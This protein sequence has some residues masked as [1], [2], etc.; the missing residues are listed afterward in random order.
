MP[1]IALASVKS[2]P[3]VTMTALALAAAWP[4]Q[5]RLLLEADPCGGDLGPWLG[6]PQ[7]QLL[8]GLADSA[9]QHAAMR[10]RIAASRARVRTGSRIII[11]ATLVLTVG[12]LAWSRAF[13]Q[14]YDTAAGQLV[15]AGVGGC[16]AAEF[17]WLHR[18]AGIGDPPRILTRLGGIPGSQQEER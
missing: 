6:L 4:G 5:R 3:G 1:L 14:P 12:L 16:F 18:I 10:M 13:L 2:S 9:R 17:W 11:A 8:A 15:L 7:R